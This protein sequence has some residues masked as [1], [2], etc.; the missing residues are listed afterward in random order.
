MATSLT[1]REP[2]DLFALAMAGLAASL[3]AVVASVL[4]RVLVAVGAVG[5]LAR[6]TPAPADV[7]DLGH[8]FQ[9]IPVAAE[10]MEALVSRSAGPVVAR[11]VDLVSRRYGAV[12]QDVD[13]AVRARRL[14]VHLDLPGVVLI[15]TAGP[16]H[17]IWAAS[18]TSIEGCLDVR[19]TRVGPHGYQ[20]TVMKVGGR[21]RHAV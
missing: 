10:P 20:R 6:S 16:D 11:V 2:S 9:V 17:T 12:P 21:H 18:N 3:T 19:S 13:V 14:A 8:G 7:L 1:L 4:R 5:L 15:S